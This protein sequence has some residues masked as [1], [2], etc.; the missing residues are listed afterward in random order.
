VRGGARVRRVK[1]L[2]GMSW[3]KVGEGVATIYRYSNPALG[4]YMARVAG[5]A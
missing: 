1:E 5:L 2:A 4:L 3:N